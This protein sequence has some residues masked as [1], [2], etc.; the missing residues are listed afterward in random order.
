M[1]IDLRRLLR[2]ICTKLL[3]MMR[4]LTY[5]LLLLT[6]ASA[7][8]VYV[9]WPDREVWPQSPQARQI[10][11]VIYLTDY[12]GNNIA[13]VDA[14]GAIAQRTYY[15]YGEPWRYPDGQQYLY[16]DKELTRA[17]GRHAYT[18]PARTLLPSL[19]RWSTPDPL[20]EQNPWDSPYAY[21]AANPINRTAPTGLRVIADEWCQQG[22]IEGLS[23]VDRILISF[24]E[25]GVMNN[26]LLNSATSNTL[27][28]GILKD[29]SNS[30]TDYNLVSAN[31]YSDNGKDVL[32]GAYNPDGGYNGITIMP[33]TSAG[34]VNSNNVDIF[35]FDQLASD[36]RVSTI[37]HELYGHAYFFE[38][39]KLIHIELNKSIHILYPYHTYM[40][41]GYNTYYDY[42]LQA[43][44]F[45]GIKVPTNIVLETWINHVVSIVQTN[46]HNNYNHGKYY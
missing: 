30:E 15:P 10:A 25:S 39:N 18:F 16:S 8:A 28:L 12:Q 3:L 40:N 35:I 36:E 29:L 6:A 31:H 9:P 7:A 17:D 22:I 23:E 44:V 11:Q 46:Y 5:L 38:L 43:T 24:N 1:A 32:L 45:E 21:C 34:D 27:L 4:M 41:K 37:T 2:Y 20:A 33:T 42:E 13:V 14:G 19:P 26:K